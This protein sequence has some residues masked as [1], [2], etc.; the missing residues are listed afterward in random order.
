[1]DKPHIVLVERRRSAHKSF[2]DALRKRYQVSSVISGKQALA[3]AVELRPVAIVV[4]AISM[5]SPGDRIVHALKV[6]Q[7]APLV[8]L[9]ETALSSDADVLLEA[10]VSVR[11][12]TT[13]LDRLTAPARTGS[14]ALV[15]G[16]FEMDIPRRVL[17]VSGKEKQLTPKLALLVEVFLR[18]PGETLDR[19]QLME[20]V[21]QTDYLG[22]TRTL[23]VHV[24][25]IRSLIETDPAHPQYLK[26]VRGIG[27]RLEV[28]AA[29]PV[30]T[31]PVKTRRV[32]A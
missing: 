16:P 1:M 32:S 2:A 14:D 29:E 20:R 10:P 22:D 3:T 19:R 4:D 30:P 28:N 27:Y 6:G 12:L 8:H 11:K 21:W 5:N 26:T 9:V 15:V 25:W 13:A 7:P 18:H 24:R 31:A 23:D 17:R